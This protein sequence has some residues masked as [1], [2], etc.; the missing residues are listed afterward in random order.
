MLQL[1]RGGGG[2]LFLATPI[3]RARKS[4]LFLLRLR[5]LFSLRRSSKP[6]DSI[7]RV[8]SLG[9]LSKP[10]RKVRK[11]EESRSKN[12]F[13]VYIINS[14]IL[15][16]PKYIT[17]ASQNRVKRQNVLKFDRSF[18]KNKQQ[19]FVLKIRKNPQII[20]PNPR[21]ACQ[22]NIPKSI[23]SYRLRANIRSTFERFI[24]IFSS[25]FLTKKL[26]LLIVCPRSTFL[27]TNMQSFSIHSRSCGKKTT[28]PSF[29][30]SSEQMVC[31]F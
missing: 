1:T 7:F 9:Y 4:L 5:T 2:G 28:L 22:T 24:K 10:R 27:I 3:R 12:V 20:S 11:V 6:P 23:P 17:T 26:F 8:N 31:E 15:P 14:E 18:A 25:S 29:F 19:I 13:F 30:F 21:L 16:S